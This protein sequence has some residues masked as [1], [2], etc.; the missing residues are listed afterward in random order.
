[1]PTDLF[2]IT[3]LFAEIVRHG[4]DEVWT[5]QVFDVVEYALFVQ[6]IVKAAAVAVPAVDRVVVATRILGFLHQF[7]KVAAVG[8]GFF[9]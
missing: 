4:A 3:W 8:V 1:M 7:V 5:E 6:K 2:V 9:R